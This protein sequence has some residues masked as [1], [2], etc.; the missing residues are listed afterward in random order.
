LAYTTF[1]KSGISGISP[2]PFT[3][4]DSGFAGVV[5]VGDILVNLESLEQTIITNVS[6]DILNL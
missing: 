3:M 2:Q 1:V 4:R 5:A 6:N